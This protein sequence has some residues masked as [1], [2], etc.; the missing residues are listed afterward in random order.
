MDIAAINSRTLVNTMKNRAMSREYLTTRPVNTWA[1][2]VIYLD[3]N[4]RMDGLMSAS[5]NE[6]GILGVT[7]KQ[8]YPNARLGFIYG[9]SNGKAKF[10]GGNS[11]DISTTNTY[12][13]GYY[14]YDFNNNLSLN[15]NFAF[16]Y[17]HNRV[18]RKV[19]IGNFSE[20][21]K[22]HYPT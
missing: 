2:D 12:I 4:H 5:Y 6:N 22:S 15:T 21:L 17:G 9:G 8:V 19:N 11:G 10:N 3:G 7:E 1:Q 13:G 20:E 16:V 14:N 18:N